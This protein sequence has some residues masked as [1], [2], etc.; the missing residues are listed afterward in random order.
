MRWW[1]DGALMLYAVLGGCCVGSGAGGF[2]G[3]CGSSASNASPVPAVATTAAPDVPPTDGQTA[4]LNGFRAYQN[5]DYP[6]AIE[7][8]KYA[9]DHS[10]RRSATTRSYVL[11][12][13]SMT[14]AI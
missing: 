4:F 13:R 9:A 5:R 11:G 12:L 7:N 14:R 2:G 10:S 1:R 3:S 6:R 8:L